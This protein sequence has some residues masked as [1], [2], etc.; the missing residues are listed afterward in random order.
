MIISGTGITTSSVVVASSQPRYIQGIEWRL[1]G[2][3]QH[4][5]DKGIESGLWSAV[6]TIED[7]PDVS[8]AFRSQVIA[9]ID[10]GIEVSLQMEKFEQVFGPEFDYSNPF[11]CVIGATD[12]TYMTDTSKGGLWGTW[13][14]EARITS[15]PYLSLKYHGIASNPPNQWLQSITRL[16]QPSASNI[17]FDFAYSSHGYEW[18]G[19]IVELSYIAENETAA[20][21]LAYYAE[22]RST[23]FSI[24]LPEFI[25]DEG[26]LTASCVLLGLD[27]GG[28]VD[29][30]EQ[31]YKYTLTLGKLQ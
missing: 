10:G 24:T 27:H 12:K 13:S 14:F 9:A 28:P 17:E 2:G 29:S 15:A 30:G 8:S 11:T 1:V 20:K 25:F 5:I 23:P 7:L 4:S 6:I 19:P 21:A 22:L 3:R 18:N 26:V 31:Y 16:K